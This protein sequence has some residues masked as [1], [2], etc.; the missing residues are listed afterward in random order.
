VVTIGSFDTVTAAAREIIAREANPVSGVF[1]EIW[2]ETAA[3]N[4]AEAFAH[5]EHTGKDGRC[6]VVKRVRH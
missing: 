5:P 4:Y 3:D 1:F 2:I 6:C